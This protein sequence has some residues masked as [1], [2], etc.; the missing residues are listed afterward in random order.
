MYLFSRNSIMIIN[1][2]CYLYKS[3]IICIIIMIFCNGWSLG[4]IIRTIVYGIMGWIFI[5]FPLYSISGYITR[6]MS[7][8][9]GPCLICR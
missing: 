1:T 9:N 7:K 2:I 4:V 6:I 8:G 5:F 3:I